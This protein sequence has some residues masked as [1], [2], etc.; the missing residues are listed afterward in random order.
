MTVCHIFDRTNT[1]GSRAGGTTWA[2]FSTTK[3]L[4]GFRRVLKFVDVFDNY[5]LIC[6]NINNIYAIIGLF[7]EFK[8]ILNTAVKICANK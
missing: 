1:C 3:L 2:Q 5:L 8:I 4:N 7:Y 6:Q